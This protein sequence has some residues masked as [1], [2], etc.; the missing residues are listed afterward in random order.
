MPDLLELSEVAQQRRRRLPPRNMEGPPRLMA[1]NSAA[2]MNGSARLVIAGI[3]CSGSLNQSS[4]ESLPGMDRVAEQCT[5]PL[6][7]VGAL[8]ESSQSGPFSLFCCVHEIP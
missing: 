7:T 8:T 2:R 5:T 3:C 6:S 1:G 4:F